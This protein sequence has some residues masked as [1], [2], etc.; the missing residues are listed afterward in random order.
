MQQ[1]LKNFRKS[2]RGRTQGLSKIFRA[3]IHRAHRAVI[4]KQTD[5]GQQLTH[6]M[7]Y[8]DR[9]LRTIERPPVFRLPRFL[10]RCTCDICESRNNGYKNT[11]AK[12][13]WC[14]CLHLDVNRCY[15][16]GPAR[17]C[18]SVTSPIERAVD[19]KLVFRKQLVTSIE[20]A[21]NS[22][23]SRFPTERSLELESNI[24]LRWQCLFSSAG[25]FDVWNSLYLRLSSSNFLS[26]TYWK[27]M[28]TITVLRTHYFTSSVPV[29]GI[30]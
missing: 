22:S 20:N 24:R 28:T 16:Q 17:K 10:T 23:Q 26:E 9:S 15:T 13:G 6:L 30:P 14:Q 1:K 7:R 21:E 27:I 4:F 29:I 5:F 2:S 8:L 19:I 11:T 18:T 25:H 12:W 3:P